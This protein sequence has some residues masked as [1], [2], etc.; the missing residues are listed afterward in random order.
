MCYNMGFYRG[1]A[2]Y[3]GY[4]C[5]IIGLPQGNFLIGGAV[6]LMKIHHLRRL[7]VTFFDILT[8]RCLYL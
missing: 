6:L 7:C 8:A 3:F 5:Q 4:L 2:V 1:R